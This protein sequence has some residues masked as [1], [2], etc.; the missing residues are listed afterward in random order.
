MILSCS[1]IVR[2]TYELDYRFIL[3]VAVPLYD[4]SQHS[5]A[6]V[7]GTNTIQKFSDN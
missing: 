7:L 2:V 6:E 5:A 3:A 4:L 1:V